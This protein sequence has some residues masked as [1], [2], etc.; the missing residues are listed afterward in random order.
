MVINGYLV[1]LTHQLGVLNAKAEIG[2]R[3]GTVTYREQA[4]ERAIASSIREQKYKDGKV[5]YCRDCGRKIYRR[6]WG[7]RVNDDV[8][9][10]HHKTPVPRGG[11]SIPSNLVVLCNRCHNQRHADQRNYLRS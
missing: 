4:K 1:L 2:K 6:K 10:L 3:K 9:I 7:G 5:Y 11:K 8:L